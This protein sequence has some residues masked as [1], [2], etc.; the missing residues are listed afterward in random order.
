M[1]TANALRLQPLNC[2]KK[3]PMHCQPNRLPRVKVAASGLFVAKERLF[4][5]KAGE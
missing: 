2:L 4:E 1:G 3:A 5:A